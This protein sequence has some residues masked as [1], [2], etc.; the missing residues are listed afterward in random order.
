MSRTMALRSQCSRCNGAVEL[1]FVPWSGTGPATAADWSCPAC[2]MV[3]QVPAI[4]EVVW[5]ETPGNRGDRPERPA[6]RP[7]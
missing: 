3:N 4:G 2:G 6:L 5:V 1:G 7:H